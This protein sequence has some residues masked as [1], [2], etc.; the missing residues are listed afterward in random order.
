VTSSVT[1]PIHSSWTISNTSSATLGYKA[2]KVTTSPLWCR[3]VTWRHS[4]RLGHYRLLR[5]NSL[6]SFPRHLA[7]NIHTYKYS[8]IDTYRHPYVGWQHRM[9]KACSTIIYRLIASCHR[10][11]SL[12]APSSRHLR[13]WSRRRRPVP[14]RASSTCRYRWTAADGGQHAG[15]LQG[16]AASSD[17]RRRRNWTASGQCRDVAGNADGRRRQSSTA[18]GQDSDQSTAIGRRRLTMSSRCVVTEAHPSLA[19]ALRSNIATTG[20]S[21][22]TTCND[23][24]HMFKKLVQKSYLGLQ[25]TWAVSRVQALVQTCAEQSSQVFHSV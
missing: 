5:G 1:W 9:L 6:P 21:L 17:G 16:E 11:L 15:W 8:Y 7:S 19:P 22:T 24:W 20:R 3:R 25:E 4:T 13:R 23:P 18:T 2:F 14:L 10:D 12:H